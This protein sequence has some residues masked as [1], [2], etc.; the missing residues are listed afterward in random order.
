MASPQVEDGYT[1]IAN[2]IL[3]ALAGINLSPYEGRTLFFLIRKTYGWKKKTDWISLS[4]F[5]KGIGLD[6]RL[7]FRALSGLQSK[8]LV[9]ICRDD[10]KH[11]TYGFQKNYDKWQMSDC[12]K[13]KTKDSNLERKVKR[14]ER[15]KASVEMT[16]VSSVEIP[17]KET[18]TKETLK[19]RE[20]RTTSKSL[21]FSL[22]QMQNPKEEEEK[23]KHEWLVKEQAAFVKQHGAYDFA[24]YDWDRYVKEYY[25]G[26][27]T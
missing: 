18:L 5:S 3:E 10:K 24:K 22:K 8:G 25:P 23:R 2:E 4:Q 16:R 13:S 6:R 20:E 15:E 17:T 12:H 27:K 19:E 1:T 14:E 21:S 9:V 7:V 26:S 11:P